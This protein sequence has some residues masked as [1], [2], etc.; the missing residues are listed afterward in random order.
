MVNKKLNFEIES[1]DIIYESPD[2]QFATAKIK[3]FSTGKSLHD[4]V[5]DVE[6]LKRTAPTLYEKPI[7]FEYDNRLR[8]FGGHSDIPII[9]GFVMPDSA[10]F[11]ILPDGRTSLNVFGKIWKKYAPKFMQVFQE[12][13]KKNK[14]VS[15]ELEVNDYNETE[16]GLLNLLDF[17]YT[18]ICVLGDFTT[19]ASPG[20][21]L[22]MISFAKEENE[23]YEKIYKEEF[24]YKS[25]FSILKNE[26]KEVINKLI[27]IDDKISSYEKKGDITMPYASLKDANPALKGINPPITLSQANAIAKQAESIGT[28]KNKNGWAIAISSFKKT[29]EVKDGHWVKKEKMSEFSS[30]DLGSGEVLKIDKKKESMSEDA[31]GNVDKTSLRNKI[32]NASN[33]K[34]LVNDVYMLVENGWEDAPSEHLKYPVMELKNNTLV[35]NHYGLSAALQRA[36]GQNESGVVGKILKI[37]EKMGLDKPN[38]E[39]M[40]SEFQEDNYLGM[41]VNNMADKNKTEEM[42]KEEMTDTEVMSKEEMTDTEVM[43]KEDGTFAK[44]ET[45]EEE[46]KETPEKEKKEDKKEGDKGDV[47]ESYADSTVGSDAEEKEDVNM[48]LNENLDVKAILSF[49]ESETKTYRQMSEKDKNKSVFYS[50]LES[51]AVEIAKGSDAKLKN[52]TNSMINFVKEASLAIAKDSATINEMSK[53]NVELKQ[54]KKNSELEKFS[55]AVEKVLNEAME[56]GMPDAEI[57]KCRNLSLEFSLENMDSY[58]NMVK[59]KAFVYAGSKDKEKDD[60]IRMQLP[61]SER[62]PKQEKLWE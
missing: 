7:I 41:E 23:E 28:D 29:H 18:A 5:C 24:E 26:V 57:E 10:E 25:D 50:L 42:A 38:E 44:E 6:T 49:L 43:S 2:S 30:E 15:V 55:F 4:T 56:V 59:A 1:V 11:E 53:E 27:D 51:C 61:F 20:A 17:T 22:Q 31:W 45:P 12:S 46:K 54:Y 37:Y 48:S 16:D 19:P 21:N 58:T 8:D 40:S 14:S 62:K 33:Y 34:S 32:L 13:G 35:Y 36:R 52:I 9:S 60:I 3:A 47:K 39:K